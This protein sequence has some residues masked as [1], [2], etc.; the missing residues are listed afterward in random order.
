[1]LCSPGLYRIFPAKAGAV[2]A[3]SAPLFTGQPVGRS[4]DCFAFCDPSFVLV[5]QILE[6]SGPWCLKNGLPDGDH[7]VLEPIH[8]VLISLRPHLLQAIHVRLL[9]S[10]GLRTEDRCRDCGQDLG[11]ADTRGSALLQRLVCTSGLTDGEIAVAP[12]TRPAIWSSC[13]SM[14]TVGCD[15]RCI[16]AGRV[17]KSIFDVQ[18]S[19]DV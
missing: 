10:G 16:W 8:Q 12:P 7:L 6:A 2:P 5:H 1:M 17:R 13:N 15:A 11:D 9:E 4:I 14:L 3:T 19:S 18:T